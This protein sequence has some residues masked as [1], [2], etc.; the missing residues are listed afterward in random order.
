MMNVHKLLEKLTI[1]GLEE[2]LA[3]MLGME[4]QVLKQKI[5]N[6]NSCF[7]HKEQINW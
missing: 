3:E 1:S 2:E 7:Y 6:C 4:A 5:R